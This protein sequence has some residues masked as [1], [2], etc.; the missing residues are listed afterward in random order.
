MLI[1]RSFGR[2]DTSALS[3]FATGCG[4][5]P[6]QNSFLSELL[7]RLSIALPPSALC[8]RGFGG[9]FIAIPLVQKCCPLSCWN[10]LFVLVFLH[11]AFLTII[12]MRD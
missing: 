11:K 9:T 12:L 3:T 2:A 4:Y 5:V 1:I 6:E 10:H 8:E 7:K